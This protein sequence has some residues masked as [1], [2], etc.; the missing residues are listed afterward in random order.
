[1]KNHLDWLLGYDDLKAIEWTPGAPVVYTELYD[2]ENDPFEF[3]NLANDPGYKDRF[4]MMMAEF[5][6][7]Y[8]KYRFA[9]NVFQVDGERPYWYK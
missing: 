4:E 2:L 6:K 3:V 1:M 5:M 7:V 8:D 9:S